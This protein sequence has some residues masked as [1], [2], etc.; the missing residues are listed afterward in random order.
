MHFIT[1]FLTGL[2]LVIGI[3]LIFLNNKKEGI[4]T[5]SLGF[6]NPLLLAMFCLKKETFVFG[7]TDFE[8]LI[9]TAVYDKLI[10]PWL[11][12]ILYLVLIGL[13]IYGLIKIG[14]NKGS[15]KYD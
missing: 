3:Y 10:E 8:F 15:K 6:I 9:Q 2:S 7:G 14:K 5:L 1:G 11:L 12:L 4:L 13:L